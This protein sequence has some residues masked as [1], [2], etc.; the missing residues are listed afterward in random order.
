MQ[1]FIITNLS[2]LNKH[3]FVYLFS[4]KHNLIILILSTNKCAL[5]FESLCFSEN[6]ETTE[7]F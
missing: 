5:Q 4:G 6:R 3:F 1:G 7:D 2:Y